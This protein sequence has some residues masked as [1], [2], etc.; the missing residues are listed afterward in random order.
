MHWIHGNKLE[1]IVCECDWLSL[2]RLK[3]L[4]SNP[5]FLFVWCLLWVKLLF[6]LH[7]PPLNSR[8][9]LMPSFPLKFLEFLCILPLFCQFWSPSSSTP[10]DTLC[11]LLPSAVLYL[12]LFLVFTPLCVC[13]CVYLPWCVTAL[14]SL[15]VVLQPV[16]LPGS[17]TPYYATSTL[18]RLS[19]WR[20]MSPLWCHKNSHHTAT[21][22]QIGPYLSYSLTLAYQ[23]SFFSTD[24]DRL[25]G[26]I[27]IFRETN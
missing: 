20:C 22:P 18:V 6:C 9:I 26:E 14:C 7:L 1:A 13:V 12:S 2:V 10:T 24:R 5:V 11:F 19:L 17:Q 27:P 3:S 21:I 25:K 16:L 23:W 15:C 8:P 4:S